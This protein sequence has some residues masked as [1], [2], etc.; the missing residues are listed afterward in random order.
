MTRIGSTLSHKLG[1]RSNICC[2]QRESTLRRQHFMLHSLWFARHV[3]RIGK[4]HPWDIIIIDSILYLEKESAYNDQWLASHN[5]AL[6]YFT[7]TAI[8][9]QLN[10]IKL[11]QRFTAAYYAQIKY[12]WGY[13]PR[14]IAK[15][16][17]SMRC[18]IHTCISR[19][20]NYSSEYLHTIETAL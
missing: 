4:A 15:Y 1:S 14:E 8:S 18:R 2:W 11:K 19:F 5:S 20:G 3:E 9:W 17:L 10:S 7:T 13:A 12:I 16:T 6:H